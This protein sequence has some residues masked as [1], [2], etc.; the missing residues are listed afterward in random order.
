MRGTITATVEGVRHVI[1]ES[2]VVGFCRAQG[3]LPAKT[4]A[5]AVSWWHEQWKLQQSTRNEERKP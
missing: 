2:W 1:P 4:T 3:G 5:E